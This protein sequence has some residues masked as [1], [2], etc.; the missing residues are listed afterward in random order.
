MNNLKIKLTF[1]VC[2]LCKRALMRVHELTVAQRL[3]KNPNTKNGDSDFKKLHGQMCILPMELSWA[4]ALLLGCAVRHYMENDL[5]E[6]NPDYKRGQELM[7]ALSDYSDTH[8]AA[9]L[10]TEK[11]LPK[12]RGFSQEEKDEMSRFMGDA[13]WTRKRDDIF[14]GMVESVNVWGDIVTDT[15]IDPV[16]RPNPGSFLPKMN[17]QDR[18]KKEG[19]VDF[20]RFSKKD[21]QHLN[22]VASPADTVAD[23]RKKSY[24]A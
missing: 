6:T 11:K 14:R 23:S 22:P 20:R 24:I 7:A 2:Q 15:Y 12:K 4:E 3:E 16:V 21:S 5:R 9:S 17:R 8:M 1:A 19:D 10:E 18:M 13:I